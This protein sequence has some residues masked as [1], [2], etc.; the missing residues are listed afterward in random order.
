MD[1][2]T[3][4]ANY[5]QALWNEGDY[6]VVDQVFTSDFVGH[7]ITPP[8]G[9]EGIK[10]NVRTFRDA[11]PGGRFTVEHI[12]GEGDMVSIRWSF[13]GVHKGSFHGIEAT[14]Q[15]VAFTGITNER[16]RDGKVVEIWMEF[17]LFA[18][19]QQLGAIGR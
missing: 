3:I 10:R 1:N 16:L 7:L 13:A 14:G 17:D 9:L 2:K 6:D 12:F 19:L 18:L 11:F 8:E 5:I 4:V 15:E